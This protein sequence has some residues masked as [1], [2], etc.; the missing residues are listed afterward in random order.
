[1]ALYLIV[2]FSIIAFS[3]PVLA[4]MTLSPLIWLKEHFGIQCTHRIRIPEF[5]QFMAQDFPCLVDIET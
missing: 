2:A 4:L 1:M 5:V 3:V